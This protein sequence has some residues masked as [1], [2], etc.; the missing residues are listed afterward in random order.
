MHKFTLFTVLLS[1]I[2]VSIVIDI[3]VNGYSLSNDYVPTDDGIVTETAIDEKTPI[4]EEDVINPM[5]EGGEENDG[6]ADETISLFS[7]A[8]KD[9]ITADILTK[10]G[11]ENGK[12]KQILI[13]K[14]FLQAISLPENVKNRLEIVNLFDFEEYLGT[15]YALHFGSLK[16]AEQFYSDLKAEALEIDG[17]DVRETNTFGDLSFYLNQEGKTKTAFSTARIGSDIYGFEYPH[18]SHQI[19]KDLSSALAE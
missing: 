7:F 11:I 5:P 14:P 9:A 3:V 8:D 6:N 2:T 4:V 1:I 10:I 13:D 17:A 15:I 19:F 12:V 18:K 16:D